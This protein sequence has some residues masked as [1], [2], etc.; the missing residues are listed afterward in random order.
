MSPWFNMIKLK[1]AQAIVLKHAMRA[2]ARKAM[3]V[4]LKDSFSR[5]L[6]QGLRAVCDR[7]DFNRSVMD[8]YAL[9][10][11]DIRH[12]GAV[13]KITGFVPAGVFPKRPI[14]K[15]ECV[16]IATGA[17]VPCGADSVVMK[18]DASPR[19]GRYVK[20]LK[21]IKNGEN[22]SFKGQDFRKGSLLLKKGSLLNTARIGLLA[23]QGKNK[24]LVFKPLSVAFLSTGDEVVEPGMP[25]KAG[26]VWNIT[27]S[28]LSVALR[29]FNI[30]PRYLGLSE[31]KPRGLLNKIKEGLKYDVFI[32]T[33]AVSE[34]DLDI[35]PSTLIKSG[36]SIKFHKV[37]LRP[38]KPFLFAVKGNCLVFGLPGNPVSS[39]VSFLLFVLPAIRKMSGLREEFLLEKGILQKGVY[40]KNDRYSLFPAAM[41]MKK[42]RIFIDPVHYN[43]S[44][45]IRAVAQADAFFM[46]DKGKIATAGSQVD[47]LRLYI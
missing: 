5:V 26:Q 6:A 45:D 14:K 43:G 29:R 17:M 28:M 20:I 18:E 21:K 39:L 47:F 36:V 10:S 25:K 2:P 40:N 23:S 22:I 42:G 31:D 38:G 35:V 4:F 11:R 32:I 9:K 33:G 13:L 30:V 15:G 34:G 3:R 37:E 44:A 12:P 1:Q 19:A 8:G 16:K 41:I 7:P 24:V 46:L 27:A